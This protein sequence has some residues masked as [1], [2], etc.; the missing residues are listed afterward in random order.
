MSSQKNTSILFFGLIALFLC[1][2]ILAKIPYLIFENP[3]TEMVPYEEITTAN[4]LQNCFYLPYLWQDE[5]YIDRLDLLF[6]TYNRT[7]SANYKLQISDGNNEIFSQTFKAGDLKDNQFQSFNL[8]NLGFKTGRFCFKISTNDGKLGNAITV[9]QNSNGDPI[10]KI[11]QDLGLPG[12]ILNNSLNNFFKFGANTDLAIFLIYFSSL[13]I[14]F[15]AIF[16]TFKA[17]SRKLD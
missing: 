6:G 8:K 17:G 15:A 5:L 1:V 9:W 2:S 14:L 12:I 16:K 13:L 3:Q 4:P 7:N 10:L 11:S